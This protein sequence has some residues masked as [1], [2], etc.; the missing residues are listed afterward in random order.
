MLALIKYAQKQTYST[1]ILSGVHNEDLVIS[2]LAIKG[3]F[4]IPDVQLAASIFT[5]DYWNFTHKIESIYGFHALEKYNTQLETE[6]INRFS[7]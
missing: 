2:Y 5:E 4:R 6:L 7:R 3:N 1:S